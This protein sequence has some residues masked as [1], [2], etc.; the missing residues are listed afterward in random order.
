[1]GKIPHCKMLQVHSPL[2][3]DPGS[4]SQRYWDHRPYLHAST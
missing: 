2:K 3:T 1:M 4:P